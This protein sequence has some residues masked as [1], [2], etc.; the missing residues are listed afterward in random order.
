MTDISSSGYFYSVP[1][2][3]SKENVAQAY[4]RVQTDGKSRSTNLDGKIVSNLEI[5]NLEKVAQTFPVFEDLVRKETNCEQE[6]AFKCMMDKQRTAFDSIQEQLRHIMLLLANLNSDVTRIGSQE[7]TSLRSVPKSD[8]KVNGDNTLKLS[9]P[10]DQTEHSAKIVTE[11]EVS[12]VSIHVLASA[13]KDPLSGTLSKPE[14]EV[15]S[16]ETQILGAE[17]DIVLYQFEGLK[18]VSNSS[19]QKEDLKEI[20]IVRHSESNQ[21][22]SQ[23]SSCLDDEVL[24][25]ELSNEVEVIRFLEVNEVNEVNEVSEVIHTDEYDIL[26]QP[27]SFDTVVSSNYP[28]VSYYL[29]SEFLGLLVYSTVDYIIRYSELSAL[30]CSSY[31]GDVLQFHVFDPGGDQHFVIEIINYIAIEFFA[32]LTNLSVDYFSNFFSV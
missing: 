9:V 31:E 8:Q 27:D 19:N 17:V 6:N 30:V 16:V 4:S 24:V 20:D 22:L 26:S 10:E 7:I 3:G 12:S 2:G 21:E 29:I 11:T 28:S 14:D 15:Y 32:I 13:S 18:V 23:I 25:S 5:R 1:G